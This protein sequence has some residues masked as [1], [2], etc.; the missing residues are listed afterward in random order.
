MCIEVRKKAGKGKCGALDWRI[1]PDDWVADHE[2]IRFSK[3]R[4]IRTHWR[5]QN[6]C[7][8]LTWRLDSS[9]TVVGVIGHVGARGKCRRSAV[10]KFI[11]CCDFLTSAYG[12]IGKDAGL[13]EQRRGFDSRC[14]HFSFEPDWAPLQCAHSG[15]L[16]ATLL[17]SVHALPP[18]WNICAQVRM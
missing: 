8:L 6:Y 5:H 13:S 15:T 11:G 17:Y 12:L 7:T 1:Q 2:K 16:R 4:P 10:N 3:T 9:K 18:L 14:A